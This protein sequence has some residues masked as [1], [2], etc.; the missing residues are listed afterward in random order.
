VLSGKSA[1]TALI[2]KERA[3]FL[4][5]NK[6]GNLSELIGSTPF[7]YQATPSSSPKTKA[8]FSTVKSSRFP[9]LEVHYHH[10][11]DSPVRFTTQSA[12]NSW[13]LASRQA[14]LH[15]ALKVLDPSSFD[16]IV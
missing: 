11:F 3:L 2:E 4:K 7:R 16:I 1:S 13:I 14:S 5:E 6:A 15:S 12:A 10:L 9:L 8:G